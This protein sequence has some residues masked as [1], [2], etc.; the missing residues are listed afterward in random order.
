MVSA[1]VLT[2]TNN[3]EISFSSPER[4]SSKL[5]TLINDFGQY[6]HVFTI[7]FPEADSRLNIK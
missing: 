4:Y 5:H 3:S 2:Q 7:L 1:L 6:R